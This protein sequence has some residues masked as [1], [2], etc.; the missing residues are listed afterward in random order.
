MTAPADAPVSRTRP[1]GLAATEMAS[2][3]SA[4]KTTAEE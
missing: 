4:A 3:A 1:P 2:P